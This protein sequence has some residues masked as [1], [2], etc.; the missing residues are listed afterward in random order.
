MSNLSQQLSRCVT[1]QARNSLSNNFGS[2]SVHACRASQISPF[3]EIMPPHPIFHVFFCLLYTC[4]QAYQNP[5]LGHKDHYLG[6]LLIQFFKVQGSRICGS[7]CGV[8]ERGFS[9]W[10]LWP[11][12]P[13]QASG[14]RTRDDFRVFGRRTRT[15]MLPSFLAEGLFHNLAFDWLKALPL[16]HA[17]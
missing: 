6:A 5:G 10:G 2:P 14:G 9:G 12:P 3:L 1:K 11:R 4:S 8:F 16:C 7:W 13:S 17:G 15:L